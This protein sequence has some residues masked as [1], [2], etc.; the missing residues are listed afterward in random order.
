M[1]NFKRL[2][3]LGM[4][5]V[6][7]AGSVMPVMA[8]SDTRGREDQDTAGT[9][10]D[11]VLTPTAY[12]AN[13]TGTVEGV[14]SDTVFKINV[15]T[16]AALDQIL[17]FTVDPQQLVYKTNGGR[18]G[19]AEIEEGATV[20]FKNVVESETAG[21]YTVA[22]VSSTSDELTIINMSSKPIEIGVECNLA[23]DDDAADTKYSG[24]YSTS[25][26]FADDG[27]VVNRDKG[28][29]IGM[30]ATGQVQQSLAEATTDESGEVTPAAKFINT[31][32]GAAGAYEYGYDSA[33]DKY[34]YSIPADAEFD[35]PTYSFQF[36]GLTNPAV[37]IETWAT[38]S[39]D[40]NGQVLLTARDVPHITLV[41]TPQVVDAALVSAAVVEEE[42]DEENPGTTYL[43]IES[44][45]PKEAVTE[46]DEEGNV[47]TISPY[48]GGILGET[49]TSVRVN[50]KEI[51]VDEDGNP[52]AVFD[53]TA[54]QSKGFV[55]IPMADIIAAYKKAGLTVVDEE[56]NDV[57][58][59][60]ALVNVVVI[61]VTTTV[62]AEAD[63]AVI[64]SVQYYAEF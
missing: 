11:G 4:S 55:N 30:I 2:A 29:Y 7:M 53:I 33:N 21:T 35:Y 56:G 1:R 49:V 22:G 38:K 40:G 13:G 42:G 20:L 26:E 18:Y 45:N 24:G 12:T 10:A 17:S 6:M 50:G 64:K 19:E 48:D 61:T 27:E 37:D 3:A 36:T 57:I 34:T 46:E 5:A 51:Y 14:V 54:A 43:H 60:E 62:D 52:A 15:P 31:A 47:T 8:A 23:Y 16:Q 41:F 59:E 32:L 39:Y 63:P 9:V 58:A 44:L 25:N 28:L